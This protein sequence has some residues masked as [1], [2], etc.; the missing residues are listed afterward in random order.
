MNFEEE[1]LKLHSEQ[2]EQRV[3]LLDQI[4]PEITVYFDTVDLRKLRIDR[5]VQGQVVSSRVDKIAKSFKP[6]EVGVLTVCKREDGF[7][8][9]ADG[10]HRYLAMCKLGVK[11]IPC[12]V[13][14]GLTLEDEA[15]KYLHLN[16]ERKQPKA[17][18]SFM[19]A[20]V[21]GNPEIMEIDRICKKHGLEI[22]KDTKGC[23]AIEK[24][25]KNYGGE[26][27]DKALDVYMNAFNKDRFNHTLL[28]EIA[29]LLHYNS[30]IKEVILVRRLK[31]KGLNGVVSAAQY[32]IGSKVAK[33]TA[34]GLSLALYAVYNDRQS[35]ENKIIWGKE[36]RR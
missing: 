30:N 1:L 3:S 13:Y 2:D 35:Q 22:G 20:L 26:L 11:E 31:E 29:R 27:L 19:V 23:T 21:A 17:I 9:I 34:E 10:Q 5:R 28:L 14:E 6:E 25:F 16:K 4:K 15:N 33:N 7:Y 18:D 32:L 36:K 8:Y 12:Q 24:I